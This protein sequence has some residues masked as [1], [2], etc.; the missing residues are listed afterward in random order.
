[1]PLTPNHE[2]DYRARN[3]GIFI[4]KSESHLEQETQLNGVSGQ[5]IHQNDY[6][7]VATALPK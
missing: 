5:P 1:M 3:S 6:R 7:P 2:N 4:V